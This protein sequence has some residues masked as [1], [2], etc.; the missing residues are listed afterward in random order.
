MRDSVTSLI[1]FFDDQDLVEPV[2]AIVNVYFER[3]LRVDIR[4]ENKELASLSKRN[5][6]ECYWS[7]VFR[8][9]P[10]PRV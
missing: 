5:I 1:L 8:M 3:V 4:V 7:I 6:P 9:W 2:E 10:M